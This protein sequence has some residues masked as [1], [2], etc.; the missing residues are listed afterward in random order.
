[1]T[2]FIVNPEARNP[3][4]AES[5]VLDDVGENTQFITFDTRRGDVEIATATSEW[6]T[7]TRP[8]LIDAWKEETLI[9]SPDLVAEDVYGRKLS[10]PKRGVHPFLGNGEWDTRHFSVVT[11][12]ENVLKFYFWLERQ[13]YPRSANKVKDLFFDYFIV[14]DWNQLFKQGQS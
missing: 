14:I 7:V 4:Y 13:G 12:R 9:S 1:M 11:A 2:E 3:L 6:R 5:M 8:I 10:L